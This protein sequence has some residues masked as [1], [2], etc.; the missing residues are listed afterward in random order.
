[1]A[2]RDRLQQALDSIGALRQESDLRAVEAKLKDAMSSGSNLVVA[3]AVKI[4]REK[5]LDTLMQACKDAYVRF[6]ENAETTDPGCAAKSEIVRWLIEAPQREEE[7]YLHGVEHV[8]LEAGWGHPTDTAAELRGLCGM[9][10]VCMGSRKAMRAVT[11]LLFDSEKATRLL[12]IKCAQT[13]RTS[14]ASLLLRARCLAGDPEADVTAEALTALVSVE[15]NDA[16]AFVAKFMASP[17]DVIAE[18]A[19]LAIGE[20]RSREGFELLHK[21]YHDI[22]THRIRGAILLGMSITRN[23]AAVDLLVDTIVS[24]SLPLA[25]DAVRAAALF[26]QDDAVFKRI[27]DAVQSRGASDLLAEWKSVTRS[28]P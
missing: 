1:M 8:Q 13:A 16:L 17:D 3:K 18:S 26:K 24:G 27:G 5:Q 2:K 7:I 22:A 25:S 11:N 10:L 15:G 4:A 9:G 20:S 28:R 21:A 6:K 19:A 14:D 12:A 23:T